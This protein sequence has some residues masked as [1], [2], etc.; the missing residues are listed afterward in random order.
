MYFPAYLFIVGLI[1][2][3]ALGQRFTFDKKADKK[4]IIKAH[5]VHGCNG[6]TETFGKS[7]LYLNTKM[8]Y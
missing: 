7:I 5:D 8:I 4:Y 1:S 6:E 2:S 3:L